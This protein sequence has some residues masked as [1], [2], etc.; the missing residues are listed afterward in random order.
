MSQS[1][2]RPDGDPDSDSDPDPSSD[3]DLDPNPD[4]DADADV[5]PDTDVDSDADPEAEQWRFGLDEVGEDAEPERPP[6]E[7]GSVSAENAFFILVGAVGT[8]LVFWSMIGL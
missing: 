7:P 1:S 8:L 2:E 6:L 4:P 5:N 3:R